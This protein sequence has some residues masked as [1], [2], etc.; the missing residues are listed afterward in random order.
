MNHPSLV[1]RRA[2]RTDAASLAVVGAGEA[3]G[4]LTAAE[5]ETAI[6]TGTFAWVA[7]LSGSIVGAVIVRLSSGQLPYSL[8]AP[9]NVRSGSA[10]Q[11]FQ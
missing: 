3:A 5:L 2:L 8:S 1:Y 4:R 11:N 9:F 6:E 7:E 10:F